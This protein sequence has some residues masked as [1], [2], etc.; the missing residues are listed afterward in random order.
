MTIG[1]LIDRALTYSDTSDRT[2]GLNAVNDAIRKSVTDGKQQVTVAS[3]VM[4]ASAFTYDLS[5]APFSI[6]TILE[7]MLVTHVQLGSGYSRPLDEDAVGN[8]RDRQHA[9]Q[10]ASLP[11]MY[12]LEGDHQLLLD[13]KLGIGDTVE[14][15]YVPEPTVYSSEASTPT[16]VRTRWHPMLAYSAASE[17]ALAENQELAAALEARFDRER[18]KYLE[19]VYGRRSGKTRTL[20]GG[21]ATR[22]NMPRYPDPSYDPPAGI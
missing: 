18:G 8:V 5:A 3:P 7:L 1:E 11:T 2:A 22:K 21:Y 16:E 14:L 20:R 12:A 4:T 19:Y 9:N 10:T 6:T 13:A 17:L 15:R